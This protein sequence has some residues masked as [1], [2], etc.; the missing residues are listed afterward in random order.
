[1]YNGVGLKIGV[2]FWPVDRHACTEAGEGLAPTKPRVLI[3]FIIGH[4]SPYKHMNKGIN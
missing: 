3:I 1:M 4:Q 2:R